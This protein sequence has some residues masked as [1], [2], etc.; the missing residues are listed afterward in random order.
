MFT[1]ICLSP[2][3]IMLILWIKLG[4]NVNNFPVT[5][6]SVGFHAGLGAIFTLYMYELDIFI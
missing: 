5:L 6:V 2:F 3:F 1:M 4:V